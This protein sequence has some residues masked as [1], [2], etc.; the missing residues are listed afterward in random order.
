MNITP[1]YYW[2]RVNGVNVSI[3]VRVEES[4]WD[5]KQ[6]AVWFFGSDHDMS[7]ERALEY[8]DF[9]SPVENYDAKKSNCMGNF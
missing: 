9:L 5:K 2:Y 3:I 7:L 8:G 6:K 4:M 1:G